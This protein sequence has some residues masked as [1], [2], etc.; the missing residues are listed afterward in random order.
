MSLPRK[1]IA[2]AVLTAAALGI[3]WIFTSAASAGGWPVKPCWPYCSASVTAQAGLPPME[4]HP[5]LNDS[6]LAGT[7]SR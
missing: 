4:P 5:R 3:S 2:V 1:V 6:G 7:A